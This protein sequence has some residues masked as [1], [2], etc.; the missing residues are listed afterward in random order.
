MRILRG[1][2]TIVRGEMVT[3]KLL[4]PGLH[5]P[6]HPEFSM[7]PE[8]AHALGKALVSC[9]EKVSMDMRAKEEV[10]LVSRLR[11][12]ADVLGERNVELRRQLDTE[13]EERRLLENRIRDDMFAERLLLRHIKDKI[14]TALGE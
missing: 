4:V 3:T 9:S 12:E 2:E 6:E 8:T 11:R 5:P 13:L 7:S 14:I 10:A 1:S